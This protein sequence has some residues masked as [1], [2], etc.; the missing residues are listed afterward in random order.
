M[1]GIVLRKRRFLCIESWS[2]MGRG[3]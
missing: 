1:A 2:S 3:Y